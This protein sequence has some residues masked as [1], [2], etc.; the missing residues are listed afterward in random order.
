MNSLVSGNGPSVAV[1]FPCESRTRVV[2]AMG[3]RPPLESTVPPFFG[4]WLS[5][6]TAFS[7]SLGGGPENFSACFSNIM[8]RMVLSP[9]GLACE[10]SASPPQPA[11]YICLSNEDRSNRQPGDCS[12]NLSSYLLCVGIRA[13]LGHD[14]ELTRGQTRESRRALNF[15]PVLE[16]GDCASAD[17]GSTCGARIPG[18]D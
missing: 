14:R 8:N 6:S 10:R 2:A 3:A 11:F 1:T 7:N 12:S 5:S 17:S 16:R 15:Q 18:G 4:S 13:A 9:L